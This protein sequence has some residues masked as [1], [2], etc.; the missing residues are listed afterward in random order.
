MVRCELLF[1]VCNYS[2]FL[3]WYFVPYYYGGDVGLLNDVGCY[4]VCVLALFAVW[5]CGF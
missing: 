3:I 2:L 5:L 1:G 4:L